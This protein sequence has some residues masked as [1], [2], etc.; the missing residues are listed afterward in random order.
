VHSPGAANH[1]DLLVQYVGG[2][3]IAATG[4]P[5]HNNKNYNAEWFID[6]FR[7]LSGAFG[8][9]IFSDS[10]KE[11]ELAERQASMEAWKN[12]VSNS[13]NNASGNATTQDSW[14]CECGQLNFGPFCSECG[15]VRPKE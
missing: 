2:E 4:L 11:K 9:N 12:A 6:F 14:Q 10:F 5:P 7:S 1:M 8:K 13:A 3:Q 15:R